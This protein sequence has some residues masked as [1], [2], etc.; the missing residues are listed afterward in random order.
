M[1]SNPNELIYMIRMHD[2]YA[3]D[4]IIRENVSIIKKIVGTYLNAYP[5]LRMYGDDLCQEAMIII[6]Y[7]VDRYRDDKNAGFM[8]FLN[9]LIHRR[10]YNCIKQYFRHIMRITPYECLLDYDESDESGGG[11]PVA[12]KN[13]M[14]EPEYYTEYRLA[15]ERFDRAYSRLTAEEK[16]IFEVSS[17]AE[18]HTAAA[19]DLTLPRRTYYNKMAKIRRK[20][21]SAVCD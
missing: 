9:L 18:S 20:L 1:Y 8:T 21:V 13:K 10:A 15:K 12:Q 17:A 16:K 11:I 3:Q 14:L 19:A 6:P 4:A 5:Q 2:S 7:A